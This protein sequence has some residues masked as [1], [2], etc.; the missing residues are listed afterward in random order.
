MSKHGY[1]RK[2]NHVRE[3]LQFAEDFSQFTNS[4]QYNGIE[5]SVELLNKLNEWFFNHTQTTDKFLADFL[6]M[7]K[8]K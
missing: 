3:H 1:P 2:E 7:H 6:L 5:S 8:I 4:Y